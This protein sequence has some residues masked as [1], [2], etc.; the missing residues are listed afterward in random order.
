MTR[1]SSVLW[2]QPAHTITPAEFQAV[3]HQHGYAVARSVQH[4]LEDFFHFTNQFGEDFVER[5]FGLKK[6]LIVSGNS[7]RME[8]E[9]YPSIFTETGP[10]HL[11][12]SPLHGELHFLQL[13]P[14]KIFWAF[15]EIASDPPGRLQIC[16]GKQLFESLPAK[17]QAYLLS[18]KVMYLRQHAA[19]L[20]PKIYDTDDFDSVQEYCLQQGYDVDLMSDGSVQTRFY[21]SAL[22]ACEDSYAFINNILP[23]GLR[24]VRE[25]DATKARICLE[26]GDLFPSQWI[27]MIWDLAQKQAFWW[28][29]QQGD[30]IMIDNTRYMHGREKLTTTGRKILVRMSQV[31]QQAASLVV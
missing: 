6:S 3:M 19:D 23:F 1:F 17:I 15:C 16:D 9:Q 22:N 4:N 31:K 5:G 20:W 7:G 11:H 14:P 26:D 30:F 21:K 24:Q 13:S 28:Y 2:E 18:H 8:A 10:E 12:E 29:W 25:P 27:E